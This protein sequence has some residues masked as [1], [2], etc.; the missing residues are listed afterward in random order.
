M[1][2]QKGFTLVELL[3]ALSLSFFIIT[4]FLSFF[5][6]INTYEKIQTKSVTENAKLQKI[7]TSVMSNVRRAG[8]WASANKNIGMGVNNNPFMQ[9]KTNLYVNQDKSCLLYSYDVNQDG[10][11]SPLGQV[12]SDERF[13]FRLKNGRLQVRPK[14]LATFSCQDAYDKW[15]N[16]TEFD[17]V[18]FKDFQINL[19]KINQNIETSGWVVSPKLQKRLVHIQFESLLPHTSDPIVTID[20]L[21][22][23]RNNQFI[24]G[25]RDIQNIIICHQL[26]SKHKVTLAVKKSA[27]KNH[28]AHG[29][30]LGVCQ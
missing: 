24:A 3:I 13:G 18:K 14:S 6:F 2:R 11:I 12:A 27:L 9:D 20:Q 29:D 22:F 7:I 16:L 4:A 25:V 30:Q 26:K 15:I 5:S 10:Q 17:E 1:D 23:V 21:V 28:L 19:I 8:Y